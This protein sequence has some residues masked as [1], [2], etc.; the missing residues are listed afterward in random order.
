MSKSPLKR[1]PTSGTR[2]GNGAGWGGPA[3]GEG[4]AGEPVPFEVGNQVAVGHG[5][6]DLY[7]LLNKEQRLAALDERK[8]NIA[9]GLVAD[10]QPVMVSAI[11]SFE[12]R[13]IGKVTQPIAAEAGTLASF[14]IYGE[15]E[16]AT[17]DEWSQANQPPG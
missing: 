8:F 4:S 12:D 16:K 3:K 1:P 14:V 7:K 11:N 13:H 15:P 5:G 9:M 6:H 17:T 10:A 2:R